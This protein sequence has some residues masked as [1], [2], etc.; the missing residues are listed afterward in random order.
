MLLMRVRGWQVFEVFGEWGII[1]LMILHI[2]GV[3][4]PFI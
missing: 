3:F 1:S 4:P 2:Y